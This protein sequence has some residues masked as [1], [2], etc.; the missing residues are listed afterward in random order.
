MEN[1]ITKLMVVCNL[2]KKQFYEA[3]R[4]MI[5]KQRMTVEEFEN[6][7]VNGKFKDVKLGDNT[8]KRLLEAFTDGTCKI[9]DYGSMDVINKHLIEPCGYHIEIIKNE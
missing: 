8:V 3:R 7:I 1:I 4:E 5:M 9:E 2:N 6:E